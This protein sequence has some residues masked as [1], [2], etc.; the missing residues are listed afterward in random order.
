M[1]LQHM[2]NLEKMVIGSILTKRTAISTAVKHLRPEMFSDPQLMTIYTTVENMYKTGEEIDIL[3]FKERLIREKQL[4]AAGGINYLIQ[5]INDPPSEVTIESD[6][7]LLKEAYL[8]QKLINALS[9]ILTKTESGTYSLKEALANSNLSIESIASDYLSKQNS[10]TM[11]TIMKQAATQIK[12]RP[13]SDTLTGIP[14]GIS[15]LD[16]LISGWHPGELTLLASPPSTGKTSVALHIAKAAAQAGFY[17]TVYSPDMPAEQIGDR[18]LRSEAPSL[19]RQKGSISEKEMEQAHTVIRYL[20]ELPLSI[21][22]SANIDMEQIHAAALIMQSKSK[23]DLIVIDSI[24]QCAADAITQHPDR[25]Q[26]IEQIIRKTKSIAMDLKIPII[27][28]S[29]LKR[30]TKTDKPCLSDLQES[31][32]QHSDIVMLLHRT[33][34]EKSDGC[35]IVA[36]HR[37]G[38]TKE[39]YFQYKE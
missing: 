13:T 2:M 1:N 35:I 39:I 8:K 19:Y 27:L 15:Q 26:E 32:E 36:K 16:M 7:Q 37:N 22:D 9:D 23:C 25:A 5:L 12:E 31:I 6:I 4:E 10:K 24:Q 11:S 30:K 33:P 17:T 34:S 18:Y 20:S 3:S 38:K 14:T 29:Q 28:V 21:N